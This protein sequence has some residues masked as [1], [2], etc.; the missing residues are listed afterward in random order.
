ML[1][2]Q[3]WVSEMD[4]ADMEKCHPVLYLEGNQVYSSGLPLFLCGYLSTYPFVCPGE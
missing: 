4:Y 3:I 1:L 2:K